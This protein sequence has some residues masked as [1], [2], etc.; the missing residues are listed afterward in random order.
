MRFHFSLFLIFEKRRSF[1]MRKIISYRRWN[2]RNCFA[3]ISD[4]SKVRFF[5]ILSWNRTH[6]SQELWGTLVPKKTRFLGVQVSWPSY[7]WFANK[8]KCSNGRF[9]VGFLFLKTFL[10]KEI[11]M[12]KTQFSGNDQ[13]MSEIVARKGVSVQST[14][15]DKIRWSQSLRETHF[16]KGVFIKI[17]S[18]MLKKFQGLRPW[19]PLTP[20]V[21]I[22]FAESLLDVS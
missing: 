9:S 21:W 12:S 10:H 18:E 11:S 17:P 20:F 22:G 5:K 8:L 1:A 19:I 16:S 4:V 14:F 3:L 7:F 2:S 15:R 13:N 6:S